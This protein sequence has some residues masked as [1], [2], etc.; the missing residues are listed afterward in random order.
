MQKIILFML[1]LGLSICLYSQG[2]QGNQVPEKDYI[3]I[4]PFKGQEGSF[5]S[6]ERFPMYPGGEKGIA[7]HIRKTV[8]YPEEARKKGISGTVIVAYMI[9]TD[10]R[11]GSTTIVQSVDPLLDAEAVRVIKAMDIW[12][13][14][15]QKGKPTRLLFQQAITFK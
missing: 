10:G 8:Q 7:E 9:E 11:I 4:N 13:P 2:G 3:E 6:V 12:K 14:A 5:S 1:A 15:I